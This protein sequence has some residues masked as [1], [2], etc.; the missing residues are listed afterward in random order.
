MGSD[1]SGS[2]D[3]VVAL[4]EHPRVDLRAAAVT[5]LAKIQ[6]DASKSVPL[7]TAALE[8]EDWTVRRDAAG[9]LGALGS[10]AKSAVP[11][12]FQMLDREIDQDAARG[13]LRSIDDAGPEA[14][15]VLIAGLESGDRRRRY[16]AM[17][18]LGKVG[19]AAKEALPILK[20]MRDEADSDR[21]RSSIDRTIE[22]IEAD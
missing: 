4:L 2:V 15:P 11:I 12:L 6:P 13:A 22:Q 14:V 5:C 7:L 17:F 21:S 18:L 16:Y 10:Q 1:G 8:D 3:S 9:A 20:R 19:G